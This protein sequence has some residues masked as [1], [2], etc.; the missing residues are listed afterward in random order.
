MTTLIKHPSAE[1][2]EFHVSGPTQ[3]H[4]IDLIVLDDDRFSVWWHWQCSTMDKPE[5]RASTLRAPLHEALADVQKWVAA[6]MEEA[7]A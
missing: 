4:W 2:T 6:A 3:D 1:G 5:R 7:D